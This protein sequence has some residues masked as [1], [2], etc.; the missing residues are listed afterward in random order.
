MELVDLKI[1]KKKVEQ[2]TE[3]GCCPVEGVGDKYPWGTRLN[4]NNEEVEKIP[5]LID[6]KVGDKVNITGEGTITLVNTRETQDGGKRCEVE[7]Q[8]EKFAYEA[9]KPLDKM[10][11]KEYREA[12]TKK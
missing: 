5:G 10:S 12:R 1:P 11:P 4:F 2:T 8:V 3:K 7:I 6:L 9:K